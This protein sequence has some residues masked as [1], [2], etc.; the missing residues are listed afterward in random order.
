MNFPP[1]LFCCARIWTETCWH[2]TV[3][4]PRTE[5]GCADVWQGGWAQTVIA[6]RGFGGE[7]GCSPGQDLN[8]LCDF[9]PL[10]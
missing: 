4:A 9:G 2:W 6:I 1:L 5:T 8:E 3:Q 7:T 10:T